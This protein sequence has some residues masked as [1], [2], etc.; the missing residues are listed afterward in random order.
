LIKDVTVEHRKPFNE[1]MGF[2]EISK[3]LHTWL[4]AETH[5]AGGEFLQ[6]AIN[7]EAFLKLREGII[8]I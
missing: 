6:V 7:M 4:V 1:I 3:P 2:L 5:L 8:I